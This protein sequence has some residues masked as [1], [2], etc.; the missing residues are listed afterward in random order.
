MR[1]R[2]T[3]NI[4]CLLDIATG[5]GTMA[6]LF[7]KNLPREW[8]EPHIVCVDK[9]K[10]ALELARQNAALNSV[11]VDF[12]NGSLFDPVKGERFDLVASN[13][14]YISEAEVP[15]LAPEVA[16]FDPAAALRGGKDGL[17]AYRTLVPETARILGEKGWIALEVGA[18]QA[19]PVSS[20]LTEAGFCVVEK[21]PDL[22]GIPRCIVAQRY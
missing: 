18:G 10:E 15:K 13:P 11:S 7:L 1:E 19:E 22:G 8:E 17:D 14:P 9:S 20:L 16:L 12:R 6:E 5:V 4:R 2:G 3:E 21:R